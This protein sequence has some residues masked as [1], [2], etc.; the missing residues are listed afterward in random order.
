[1][2]SVCKKLGWGDRWFT[3]EPK[4]KSGGLLLGWEREV[5]VHQIINTKFSIEVEFETVDIRGKTWA[6]FVYAS[7]KEGV[8]K[9]QW[10]EL[11]SRKGSWGSNWCLGGDLNDIREQD[12]KRGGRVRPVSS[13]CT[14]QRFIENMEMQEIKFTGRQWTWANN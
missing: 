10:K 9:E 3:V 13:Y 14:F 6:V 4:G 2:R 8:R 1:M 5:S 7:N 11:L 12:E